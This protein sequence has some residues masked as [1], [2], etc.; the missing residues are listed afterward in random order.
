MTNL[1]P[2]SI[3]SFRISCTEIQINSWAIYLNPANIP[4]QTTFSLKPTT[5][6][7]GDQINSCHARTS[8]VLVIKVLPS[9]NTLQVQFS[10]GVHMQHSETGFENFEWCRASIPSGFNVLR[11]YRCNY[12]QMFSQ[13]FWVF[14]CTF[15]FQFE[16]P[17]VEQSLA[18]KAAQRQDN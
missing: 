10:T 4:V 15:L 16:E 3:E 1:F 7:K 13:S 14:Q 8:R 17:Q 2:L 5:F 6:I 12:L 11:K 18:P 9:F